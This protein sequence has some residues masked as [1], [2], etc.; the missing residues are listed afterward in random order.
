[1]CGEHCSRV[2]RGGADPGSS[3]RVRGTRSASMRSAMAVRIIPACAGNTRRRPYRARSPRDHPRVCGE[4]SSVKFPITKGEGSS[5]RVRG[6]LGLDGADEGEHGIIPACA[7][8]TST[9]SS[10]TGS[11][12]D[13]PRV[14]GEHRIGLMLFNAYQGSSPRV[15]GTR[16]GGVPVS[17]GLG[18]IPACAGNTRGCSGRRSRSR[19]HPRVCGEHHRA[20]GGLGM[21]EG[22]SPRVRGT[23]ARARV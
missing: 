11:Q 15:R 7:G 1:M 19:D 3:P 16:H 9:R 18:I 21:G 4:H 2:C 8:N 20:E 5:P 6:T 22:S 17:R 23:P 13:H 14:C 10:G 12:R